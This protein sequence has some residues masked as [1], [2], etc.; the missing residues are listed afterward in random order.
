[1]VSGRNEQRSQRH[2]KEDQD[3]R[4]IKEVVECRHRREKKCGRKREMETQLG[5]GRQ[6]ESKA[7][8]VDSAIQGQTVE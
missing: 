5:E 6:G 8:E 3:L 1:M 4:Q 7:L 2:S